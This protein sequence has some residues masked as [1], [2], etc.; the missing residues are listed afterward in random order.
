MNLE[1]SIWGA[2]VAASWLFCVPRQ[3]FVPVLISLLIFSS[4]SISF[5]LQLLLLL[6][7]FS[8][9]QASVGMRKENNGVAQKRFIVVFAGSMLALFGHAMGPSLQGGLFG[10]A[11]LLLVIPNGV[12]TFFLA[13]FHERLTLKSYLGAVAIPAF[14]ALHLL[15][16][17]RSGIQGNLGDFYKYALLGIGLFTVWLAGGMGFAR[18]RI[19]SVLIY[20]TQAWIGFALMALA[21]PEDSKA[22]AAISAISVFAVT[23][24][25]LLNY[26]VQMGRGYFVFARMAAVGLPGLVGFSALYMVVRILLDLG[27]EWFVAG[28]AGIMFQ[29]ATLILCRPRTP[30]TGNRKAKTG[31][32]L[33][34]AVQVLSGG[35]LFWLASG[36]LK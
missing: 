7:V 13:R 35:G 4:S 3:L 34:V 5:G 10:L 32:A 33:V 16:K 24:A 23:S 31:F 1:F 26:S 25:I 28:F 2:I 17:W 11:G 9:A 36:G 6:Q 21:A 8:F 12:T 15:L 19:R 18:L 29:V 20:W 22:A 30:L 14:S 27:M